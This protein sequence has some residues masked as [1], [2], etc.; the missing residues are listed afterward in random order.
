MSSP[1]S[2]SKV[3]NKICSSPMIDAKEIDEKLV[4]LVVFAELPFTFVK[5]Q[6]FI[7]FC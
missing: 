5:L 1:T 6:K 2:Q 3:Q 4:D 7:K